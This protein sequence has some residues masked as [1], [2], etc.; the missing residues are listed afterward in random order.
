VNRETKFPAGTPTGT[1]AA[2]QLTHGCPRAEL[3]APSLGGGAA[4]PDCSGPLDTRFY[5]HEAQ[6]S[7][8]CDDGEYFCPGCD[9]IVTDEYLSASPDELMIAEAISGWALAEQA[10]LRRARA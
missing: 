2:Q 10:A 1:T 6:M 5:D 4:C 8:P 3:P 7:Y 9:M